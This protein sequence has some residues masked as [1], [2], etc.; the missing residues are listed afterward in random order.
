MARMQARYLVTACHRGRMRDLD[1]IAGI[2]LC[3]A[4]CAAFWALVLLIYWL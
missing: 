4:A 2:I 3:G 1:P